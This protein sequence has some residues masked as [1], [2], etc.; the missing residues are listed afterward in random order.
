M[1]N[2]YRRMNYSR[3]LG[4]ARLAAVGDL[5]SDDADQGFYMESTPAIYNPNVPAPDVGYLDRLINALPNLATAYAGYKTQSDINEINLQRVRAGQAPLSASYLRA[6]QPQ[7][8]VNVGVSP[9]VQN[10]LL[11]AGLGLGALFI[12]KTLLARR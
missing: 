10:L 2:S 12:G 7:V 11:W 5:D 8:G 3:G 6:M 9:Q 4:S 1:T